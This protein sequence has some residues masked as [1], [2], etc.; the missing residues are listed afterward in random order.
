MRKPE[1]YRTTADPLE[2]SDLP[3]SV[4]LELSDLEP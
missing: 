1:R 3:S 2:L 4:L